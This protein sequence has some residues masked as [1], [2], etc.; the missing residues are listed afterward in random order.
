MTRTTRTLALMLLGLAAVGLGPAS[1]SASAEPPVTLPPGDHWLAFAHE[2]VPRAYLLH[3]P[4]GYDGRTPLPLV[5]VFHGGLGNASNI[6]Q[7][8]GFS[9]LADE[10]GFL[11]AYPQASGANWNDGQPGVT[12]APVDDAGFAAALVDHIADVVARVDRERVYATGMSSGGMLS[13]RIGLERSRT[14]A[15]VAPVAAIIGRELWQTQPTAPQSVVAFNGTADDKTFY[16]GAAGADE[17]GPIAAA[18]IG[19]D[20]PSVPASMLRWAELNQCDLVS[21]ASSLPDVDPSDGTRV[22]RH[23]YPRCAA[24]TEVVLYEIVGG[25]HSWPGARPDG[26]SATDAVVSR[27]IDATTIIWEFFERHT[28]APSGAP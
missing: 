23:E 19:S 16:E 1:A 28:R 17:R 27:D 13:N 11:V 22:V 26:V 24:G 12:T 18:I 15:A 14:T 9:A 5:L 10:E 6:S 8:T 7:K 25:G 2:G 20:Q 3:V 4:S 21:L